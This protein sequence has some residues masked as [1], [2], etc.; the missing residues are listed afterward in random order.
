MR[1]M[2]L[3]GGPR[4]WRL[5]FFS[6]LALL[7]ADAN[8]QGASDEYR[9]KAAFLYHFAQFV[10]WPETAFATPSSPFVVCVLG[11]NPFGADLQSLARRAVGKHPIEL[12]LLRHASDMPGGCH[13]VYAQGWP[14]TNPAPP[15]AALERPLLIVSS[16][17]GAL[18]AGATIEF[19]LH[20]QRVR[21]L[22]NLEQARKVGLKISVKLIEIALPAAPSGS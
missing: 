22:L 20:Q 13:L 1:A 6:T 4:R 9:L 8:A 7:L 10:E 17:A 21:W 2:I 12:R 14:P 3:P 16:Q 5:A 18:R 11:D 19:V 15:A